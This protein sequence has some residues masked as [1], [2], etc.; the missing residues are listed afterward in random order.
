[1]DIIYRCPDCG[2][3]TSD[4]AMA[5]THNCKDLFKVKNITLACY[6]GRIRFSNK[7]MTRDRR[8]WDTALESIDTWNSATFVGVY[9]EDLSEEHEKKL[10]N[11]LLQAAIDYRAARIEGLEREIGELRSHMRPKAVR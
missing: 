4:R 9:T 10:K 1:M 3:E 2:Y 6:G 11:E 8:F 7:T 5:K